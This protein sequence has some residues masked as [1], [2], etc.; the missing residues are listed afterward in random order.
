MLVLIQLG[1]RPETPQQLPLPPP[2]LSDKMIEAIKLIEA[3][4][5]KGNATRYGDNA[6]AKS[7]GE[8]LSTICRHARFNQKRRGKVKGRTFKEMTEADVVELK[9][10]VLKLF[11][12]TGGL[13]HVSGVCISFTESDRLLSIDRIDNKVGY[14]VES[15]LSLILRYF[16]TDGAVTVSEPGKAQMD[17]GPIPSVWSPHFA[18]R[19]DG[20]IPRLAS[21]GAGDTRRSA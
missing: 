20:E 2:T 13:C 14:E 15:N 4:I 5:P 11:V 16:N 12:D 9:K 21:R 17:A 1:E 18:G 10:R 19:G 6:L 8:F 3:Q 7:I